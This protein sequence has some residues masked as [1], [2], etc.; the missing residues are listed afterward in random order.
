MTTYRA[1]ESNENFV[2]QPPPECHLNTV[3][4]MNTQH[5]SS[6]WLK[7]CQ[8]G[9][10]TNNHLP[11]KIPFP[12][13]FIF[14]NT[15]EYVGLRY[16]HLLGSEQLWY[17]Q[18]EKNYLNCKAASNITFHS[19]TLPDYRIVIQLLFGILKVGC[20]IYFSCCTCM[21]YSIQSHYMY[22]FYPLNSVKLRFISY[23]GQKQLAFDMVSGSI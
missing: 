22:L 8:D 4:G 21:C 7:Y 12:K 3:L 13:L 16:K 5:E 20:Y 10:M 6:V 19:R 17:L 14:Q 1:I 11:L 15:S 23:V 2:H 18:L 9:H